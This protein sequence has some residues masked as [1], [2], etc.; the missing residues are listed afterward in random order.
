MGTPVSERPIIQTFQL[1]HT[2]DRRRW[3]FRDV[4]LTIAAGEFVFLTGP[5]GAG[6]TTF[7]RLLLR[8][9][10][11]VEG[12]I[13]IFGQ[14]LRTIPEHRLFRLRRQIGFVFQDFRLIPSYTVLENVTLLL[15]LLGVPPQE[16]RRQAIRTLHW[17]GLSGYWRSYPPALSGGEQQRVAIARAIIH[18]PR[19]LL[20][21]E[22][23]GNLDPEMSVEIM[24]LFVRINMGGT[25]VI[26]ATHDDRLIDLVG[27]KVLAIERETIHLVDERP[28]HPALVSGEW[29]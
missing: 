4:N 6:K 16:Q 7:L 5:S 27:G 2:Y 19:I 3:L 23:T 26:V 20:A 22:P 18:R 21:D 12:Q 24:R 17:V 25:T 14:N 29:Q 15:R 11:P 28:I 8:E 1:G 10:T 13:L 9:I